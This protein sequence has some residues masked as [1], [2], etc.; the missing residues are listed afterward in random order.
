[1]KGERNSIQEVPDFITVPGPKKPSGFQD[2]TTAL[3]GLSVRGVKILN[4]RE[5]IDEVFSKINLLNSAH[6]E[7]ISPGGFMQELSSLGKSNYI[8][9]KDSIIL[10]FKV[11]THKYKWW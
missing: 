1:M 8:T 5:Y 6:H 3:E 4:L 9:P 11:I 2:H 10:F 7:F